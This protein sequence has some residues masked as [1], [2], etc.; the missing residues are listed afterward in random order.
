MGT[1]PSSTLLPSG[2]KGRWEER[3]PTEG[4]GSGRR[5][6]GSERT[7]LKRGDSK[8][9]ESPTEGGGGG[10]EE[11]NLGGTYLKRQRPQVSHLSS[12]RNQRACSKG[13]LRG[14]LGFESRN[15]RYSTQQGLKGF[16][17]EEGKWGRIE[18][19]KLKSLGTLTEYQVGGGGGGSPYKRRG[20]SS[21]TTGT[22]KGRKA[23]RYHLHPVWETSLCVDLDQKIGEAMGKLVKKNPERSRR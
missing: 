9:G 17:E 13:P 16:G 23:K 14:K 21:D 18:G 8:G 20:K 1:T 4:L 7:W 10:L 12:M 15:V 2:K 19:K 3:T 22:W 6:Y 5:L 11:K